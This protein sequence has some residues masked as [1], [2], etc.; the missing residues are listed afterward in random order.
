M[1]TQTQL[2]ACLDG[3]TAGD[4]QSTSSVAEVS[5]PSLQ[6]LRSP[7]VLGDCDFLGHC[8]GVVYVQTMIVRSL[9]QTFYLYKILRINACV[10]TSAKTLFVPFWEMDSRK[11]KR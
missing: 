1:S 5:L 6:P 3:G 9:E 11:N 10:K 8:T 4:T 2:L 7:R